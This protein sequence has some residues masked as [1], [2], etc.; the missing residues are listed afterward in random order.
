MK[1]K[2][3]DADDFFEDQGEKKTFESIMN[4]RG[5]LCICPD[6]GSYFMAPNF[7]NKIKKEL[8]KFYNDIEKRIDKKEKRIKEEYKNL[9]EKII[10]SSEEIKKECQNKVKSILR[11][12]KWEMESSYEEGYDEAE[13]RFCSRIKDG[14]INLSDY[15][16]FNIPL[17]NDIVNNYL[18][19][20]RYME[21]HADPLNFEQKMMIRE[22]KIFLNKLGCNLHHFRI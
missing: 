15:E 4:N 8:E 6:C 17:I 18:Q 13:R 7:K 14:G 9:S 5:H 21:D 12:K 2:R 10:K 11:E 19:V 22:G 16:L 3:L 20:L 1:I